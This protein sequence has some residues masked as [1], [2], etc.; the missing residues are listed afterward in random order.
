M[1][2][3]KTKKNISDGHYPNLVLNTYEHT[4]KG[5]TKNCM[6]KII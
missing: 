1:A 5:S 3:V 2:K 6:L 4:A